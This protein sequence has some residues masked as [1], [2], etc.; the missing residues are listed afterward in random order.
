IEIPAGRVHGYQVEI[1]PDMK[2]KR[3]WSAGI[4]DEGRRKWLYPGP[5]DKAREKAFSE[6]GLKVFKPDDWNHVK[7]E[8]M[9]DSI[10]T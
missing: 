4:F 1:D 3:M 5:G 2:R 10:K 6:Q 7:V 8:A 9:G